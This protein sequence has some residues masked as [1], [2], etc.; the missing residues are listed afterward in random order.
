MDVW[1]VPVGVHWWVE[2]QQQGMAVGK[3]VGG[4]KECPHIPAGI[5]VLHTSMVGGVVDHGAWWY[6]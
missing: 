1:E 6:L 4:S 3:R 5:E 2:V